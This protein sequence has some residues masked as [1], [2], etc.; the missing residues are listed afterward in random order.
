MTRAGFALQ[1]D[2]GCETFYFFGDHCAHA[3]EISPDDAAEPVGQRR[4][5]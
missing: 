5:S 3:F 1:M 2:F 4:D